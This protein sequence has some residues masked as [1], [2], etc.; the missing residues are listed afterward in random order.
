[1]HEWHV[2]LDDNEVSVSADGWQV[3]P[4]GDLVFL[5]APEEG[6]RNPFFLRAFAV[7]TWKEVQLYA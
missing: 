6:H 2:I 1:M 5:N 7:G 3:S 4:N